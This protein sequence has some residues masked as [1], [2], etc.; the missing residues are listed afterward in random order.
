MRCAR[1]GGASGR[2][3]R[4]GSTG[5]DLMQ[6]ASHL[7]LEFDSGRDKDNT[8]GGG[9]LY[10]GNRAATSPAFPVCPEA[11]APCPV[12]SPYP[13]GFDIK[14]GI[15]GR[16]TGVLA[17]SLVRLDLTRTVPCLIIE[18]LLSTWATVSGISKNIG[19]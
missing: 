14:T 1:P 17:L 2:L 8:G 9:G 16:A 3:V 4:L 12:S 6:N 7:T 10:V 11:F 13:G 5:G 15:P 19:E 18:L